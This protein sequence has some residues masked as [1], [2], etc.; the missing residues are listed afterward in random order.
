MDRSFAAFLRLPIFDQNFARALER[1]GLARSEF[2]LALDPNEQA[3]EQIARFVGVIDADQRRQR[4]CALG[5]RL[6]TFA[7]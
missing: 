7:P 3:D 4:Y 2:W 1:L 5:D 6:C